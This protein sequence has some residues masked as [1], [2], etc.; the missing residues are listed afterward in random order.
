MA[1]EGWRCTGWAGAVPGAET[2]ATLLLTASTQQ[3]A[4]QFVEAENQVFLLLIFRQ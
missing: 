4:A 2:T 1:A 3:V